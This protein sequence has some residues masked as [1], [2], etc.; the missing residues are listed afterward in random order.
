MNMFSKFQ[1]LLISVFNSSD[2]IFGVPVMLQYS[3]LVI[4]IIIIASYSV[5]F[6]ICQ[7]ISSIYYSF[8]VVVGDWYSR[9]IKIYFCVHFEDS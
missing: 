1:I 4:R 3:K 7:K 5:P 8:T 9:R 6:E 2:Y